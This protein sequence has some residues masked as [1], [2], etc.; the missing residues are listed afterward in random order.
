MMHH[1]RIQNRQNRIG[2]ELRDVGLD[3]SGPLNPTGGMSVQGRRARDSRSD[4]G[5]DV[6]SDVQDPIKLVPVT[7]GLVRS[8]V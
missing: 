2:L 5:S 7:F 8:K 6:K 3:R 4:R 1:A